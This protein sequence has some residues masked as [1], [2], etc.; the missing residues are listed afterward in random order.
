[1]SRSI[2][3][4]GYLNRPGKS[5]VAYRIVP[6]TFNSSR[7]LFQIDILLS[8]P[9]SKKENRASLLTAEKACRIVTENHCLDHHIRAYSVCLVLISSSS[10]GRAVPYWWLQGLAFSSLNRPDPRQRRGHLSE[11]HLKQEQPMAPIPGS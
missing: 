10:L 2:F 11:G 6:I 9:V 5:P 1:V 8:W 4:D 7:S 3:S